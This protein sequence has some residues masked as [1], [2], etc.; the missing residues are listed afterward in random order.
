[1]GSTGA[2]SGLQNAL[3]EAFSNKVAVP[4]T[5]SQPTIRAHFPQ[6]VGAGPAEHRSARSPALAACKPLAAAVIAFPTRRALSC[7]EDHSHGRT[8]SRRAGDLSFFVEFDVEERR[9]RLHERARR[10]GPSRFGIASAGPAMLTV[11][12]LRQLQGARLEHLVA[13]H[14]MAATNWAT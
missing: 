4:R 14:F 5:S 12:A 8:M 2:T 10:R 6:N 13:H 3:L 11:L 1:M 9:S 7:L